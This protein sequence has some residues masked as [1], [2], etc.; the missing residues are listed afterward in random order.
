MAGLEVSFD[1]HKY[2]IRAQLSTPVL[3]NKRVWS[4]S[5]FITTPERGEEEVL[6]AFLS[7]KDSKEVVTTEF[8]FQTIGKLVNYLNLAMAVDMSWS[9]H[10]LNGEIQELQFKKLQLVY[11]NVF[12]INA[13]G[14][15]LGAGTRN[16]QASVKVSWGIDDGEVEVALSRGPVVTFIGL[17]EELREDDKETLVAGREGG[18]RWHLDF[19]L[20]HKLIPEAL[21]AKIDLL[22]DRGRV[23]ASLKFALSE[24]GGFN[25]THITNGMLDYKTT[26]SGQVIELENSL[27]EARGG[28]FKNKLE[29]KMDPGRSMTMDTVLIYRN[30]PGVFSYGLSN[31]FK[32]DTWINPLSIVGTINCYTGGKCQVALSAVQSG[33]QLA[34]I[35]V[36][37]IGAGGVSRSDATISITDWFNG[38]VSLDAAYALGFYDIKWEMAL[39]PWATLSTGRAEVDISSPDVAVVEIIFQELYEDYRGA[40]THSYNATLNLNPEIRTLFSRSVQTFFSSTNKVARSRTEELSSR[41]LS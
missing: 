7:W 24:T 15:I 5:V 10:Q 23:D 40:V 35:E 11:P 8:S 38:A 20:K 33:D 9:T 28:S 6:R 12:G 26:A 30:E 17:S 2:G 41:L 1:R 32:L 18:T 16:S 39:W 37:H 14:E 34:D 36:Q 21:Q 13:S 4:P 19:N 31:T 22:F 29:F 25:V 3:V 27:A